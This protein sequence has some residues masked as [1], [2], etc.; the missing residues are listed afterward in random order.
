M[1][2]FDVIT[3]LSAMEMTFAELGYDFES[4]KAIKAAEDVLKENWE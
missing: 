4:G 2:G 3:A 1:G